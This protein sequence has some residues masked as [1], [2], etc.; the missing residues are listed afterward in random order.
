MYIFLRKL[1]ELL[2]DITYLVSTGSYKVTTRLRV[3]DTCLL[4]MFFILDQETHRWAN[5]RDGAYYDTC[6]DEMDHFV[7]QIQMGL[8]VTQSLHGCFFFLI[9]F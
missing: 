7:L 1:C 6:S 8:P 9:Y 3:Y 2:L 4:S 5:I